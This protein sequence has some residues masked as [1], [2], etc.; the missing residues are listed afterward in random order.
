M[1]FPKIATT[2]PKNIF[3]APMEGLRG[4]LKALETLTV[5]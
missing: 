3:F 4:L 1:S 5:S 2:C